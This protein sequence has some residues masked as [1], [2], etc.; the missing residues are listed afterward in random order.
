MYF[1]IV[2][3]KLMPLLFLWCHLLKL[4][5]ISTSS[6]T[7]NTTA[8]QSSL[9]VPSQDYYDEEILSIDTSTLKENFPKTSTHITKNKNEHNN[10]SLLIK[11][12][13]HSLRPKHNSSKVDEF[14]R[15][16]TINTSTIQLKS[17]LSSHWNGIFADSI[18][19]YSTLSMALV[20]TVFISI[21]LYKV[22][23]LQRHLTRSKVQ[24][25]K[26]RTVPIEMSTFNEN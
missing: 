18:L 8:F 17:G 24:P 9:L 10:S 21:V 4:S 25:K 1:R 26:Y 11:L 5:Y 23:G 2:C 7:S 16:T 6:L 14:G 3:S 15:E 13:T 22:V 19:F 20:I 12:L